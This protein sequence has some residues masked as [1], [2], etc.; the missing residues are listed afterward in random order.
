MAPGS[1]ITVQAF[2]QVC[3]TALCLQPGTVK[4]G[5]QSVFI[6][7]LAVSNNVKTV[8]QF[9]TKILAGSLEILTYCLTL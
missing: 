6:F 8:C 9:N 4:R 2:L 7:C 1:K 3:L 5:Y